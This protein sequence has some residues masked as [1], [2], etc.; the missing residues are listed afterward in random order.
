MNRHDTKKSILNIISKN[1]KICENLKN[2]YKFWY[3][4]NSQTYIIIPYVQIIPV[5]HVCRIP[6]SSPDCANFAQS[7]LARSPALEICELSLAQKKG[8]PGLRT[9]SSL[10]FAGQPSTGIGQ[11]AISCKYSSDAPSLKINRAANGKNQQL[12]SQKNLTV[13]LFWL[14]SYAYYL[15][16]KQAWKSI[17]QNHDLANKSVKDEKSFKIC[18]KIC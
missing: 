18:Q 14:R 6:A 12:E 16:V 15:I 11:L 7:W 2:Q 10:Q 4:I 13:Y 8:T 17:L 5:L 9:A 1:L 3:Q